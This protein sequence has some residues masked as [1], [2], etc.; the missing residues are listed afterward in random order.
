ML[1]TPEA[2]ARLLDVMVQAGL[3]N[4][5]HGV[6]DSNVDGIARDSHLAVAELCRAIVGAALAD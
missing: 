2:E 4:S 3:I 5:T 1:H 6:I